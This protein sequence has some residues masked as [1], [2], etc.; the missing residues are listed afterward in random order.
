MTNEDDN[1]ISVG[2]MCLTAFVAKTKKS[3][4]DEAFSDKKLSIIQKI[5]RQVASELVSR[6]QENARP[7]YIL[8]AKTST[9]FYLSFFVHIILL[10]S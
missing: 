10:L 6:I 2:V 8:L 3:K 9:H 7:L 5:M 1:R 4:P